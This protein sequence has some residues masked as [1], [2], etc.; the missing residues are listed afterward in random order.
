MSRRN[1]LLTETG[2]LPPGRAARWWTMP[3]RVELGRTLY[4]CGRFLWNRL[5]RRADAGVDLGQ[6][7]PPMPARPG[8]RWKRFRWR[9]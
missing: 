5:P 1:A 4:P 9:K 3:D 2:R 7:D 6:F 8:T